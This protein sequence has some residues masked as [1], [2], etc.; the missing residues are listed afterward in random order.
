MTT[1]GFYSIVQ[2]CPDRFRA[3]AVNVGLVLLCVDPHRVQVQISNDLR[4]ARKLF[5]V[6]RPELKLAMQGLQSRILGLSANLRTEEDLAAFAASRA[7]DLRL[8]TPRLAKFVDFEADFARLFTELVS[9][10]S[11]ASLADQSPAEVLPPSLNKVFYDLQI[12]NRIWNPGS[13]SVP[14]FKRKLEIPYAY[15]NGSVNLIKPHV[16]PATKRAE[17]QAAELAINGDL[18]QRHPFDEHRKLIIISTQES[19]QQARQID[20]H[21]EPLFREYNIRL[22]RPA[23]FDAFASEVEQSAH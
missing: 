2:Y 15:K 22:I 21:V 7:N 9:D 6:E 10:S 8:T 20:E 17:N 19:A 23:Y 14:I 18:I 3:E 11:T 16:F 13:I 12:Q 5:R 1:K 4:R